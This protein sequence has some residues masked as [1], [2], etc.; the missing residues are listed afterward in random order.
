M[1]REKFGSA[2]LGT[3]VIMLIM[4]VLASANSSWHWL[5]DTRP[6]DLL[7]VAAILTIF[8]EALLLVFKTDKTKMGKVLF[9]V[10]AANIASFLLPY[11]LGFHFTPHPYDEFTRFL[12]SAPNYIIG[13]GYLLLTLAT[14]VPIVYNGLKRNAADKGKFL[15]WVFIANG[16]TTL[17]V[18]I[19]ER[20]FCRGSW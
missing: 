11:T 3:A 9:F 17:M 16:I 5:T 7:P 1:K 15:K 20:A 13:F 6:F 10:L 19:I 4:P 14:E 18:A 12:D 2:A 8:T